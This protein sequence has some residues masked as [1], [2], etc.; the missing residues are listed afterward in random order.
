M[1]KKVI[2]LILGII[3]VSAVFYFINNKNFKFSK[4]KASVIELNPG[5]SNFKDRNLYNCVINEYN[6]ENNTNYLSS[7]SLSDEELSSIKKLDCSYTVQNIDMQ[8]NEIKKNNFDYEFSKIKEEF[9]LENYIYD[10][11]DITDLSGLEKLKNL[12]E[13]RIRVPNNYDFKNNKNLRKLYISSSGTIDLSE[14]T[15]L[16]E[17][18]VNGDSNITGLQKLTNL[19]SLGLFNV[20]KNLEEVSNLVNLKELILENTNFTKL[21]LLNNLLNL[22][23]LYLTSSNATLKY[24]IKL[25]DLKILD[26]L[27]ELK[28]TDLNFNSDLMDELPILNNLIKLD[29]YG[30]MK[31]LDFNLFPNLKELSIEKI[32][33]MSNTS[34]LEDFKNI[35]AL[36]NL[37]YLELKG[38]TNY[39]LTGLENFKKLKTFIGEGQLYNICYSIENFKGSLNDYSLIPNIKKA[40]I[41]VNRNT[42]NIDFL[43]NAEEIIIYADSIN[44]EEIE[45]FNNIKDFPNLIT[46][47]DLGYQGIRI[48][49]SVLKNMNQ[50]ETFISKYGLTFNSDNIDLSYNNKLKNF[51]YPNEL[52]ISGLSYLPSLE[53]LSASLKNAELD[54]SNCSNLKTLDLNTP[55]LKELNLNNNLNLEILNLSNTKLSTLDLSNNKKLKIFQSSENS[56]SNFE[57]LVYLIKGFEN[58][59]DLPVI[60]PDQF[61][62]YSLESSNGSTYLDEDGNIVSSPGK[63]TIILKIYSDSPI[64]V[65]FN[66]PFYIKTNIATTDILFKNYNYEIGTN[67]LFTGTDKTSKKIISNIKQNGF[68]LSAAIDNNVLKVLTSNKVVQEYKLI[69]L[70]SSL[71]EI[72]DTSIKYNGE[73]NINNI[74]INNG[75]GQVEGNKLKILYNNKILKE[76]T[77]VEKGNIIGDVNGD[78]RVSISDISL[79]YKHVKYILDLEGDQAYRSDLNFDEDIT[80]SDVQ[81][82]Y[83]KIKDLNLSRGDVNE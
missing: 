55:S 27:E 58:S 60:L 46:F 8:F 2:F 40:Y 63:D 20:N 26:N 83:K 14:N 18:Y 16:E 74:T 73:F 10:Y 5:N 43:K 81:S 6:K 82:L 38:S 31:N 21:S 67:Y 37:E 4:L 61:K 13:L 53:Y 71:Y 68:K 48:S 54:F 77:L 52:N 30:D 22:R 3:L 34:K 78:G 80:I 35:F 1:F 59:L 57:S 76:Y 45:K 70:Y 62:I 66:E 72:D 51:V 36:S 47:I 32:P 28:I 23:K 17:L 24:D 39:D 9:F 11:N 49:E 19:R 15:N 44:E 42:K 29:F 79:Q 75:I 65:S 41:N 69:N 7:Y 25:K 56:F 64:S 50:L 12:Q 33:G